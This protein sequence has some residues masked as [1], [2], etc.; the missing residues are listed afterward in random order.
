VLYE[1]CIDG[2]KP[3]PTVFVGGKF[4]GSVETLMACHNKDARALWL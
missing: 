3:V 2:Q 1:L 4:L